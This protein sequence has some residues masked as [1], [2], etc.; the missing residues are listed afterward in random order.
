MPATLKKKRRRL[1][2]SVGTISLT[3]LCV[4]SVDAVTTN[5]DSRPVSTP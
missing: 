3:R 5:T 1:F 2:D 4:A